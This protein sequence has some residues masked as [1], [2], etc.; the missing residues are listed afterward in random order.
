M[1]NEM[2][3]YSKIHFKWIFPK[4]EAWREGKGEKTSGSKIE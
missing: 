4:I 3:L 1:E 2:I